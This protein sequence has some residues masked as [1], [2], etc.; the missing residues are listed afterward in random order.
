[1][2]LRDRRRAALFALALEQ[3]AS[4]RGNIT[5]ADMGVFANKTRT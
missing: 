4:E 5:G 3:Y 1:M 2:S